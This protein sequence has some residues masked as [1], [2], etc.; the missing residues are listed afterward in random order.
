MSKSFQDEM[1]EAMHRRIQKLTQENEHLRKSRALAHPSQPS[2][3]SQPDPVYS[4]PVRPNPVSPVSPVSPDDHPDIDDEIKKMQENIM[5]LQLCEKLQIYADHSRQAERDQ[6]IEKYKKLQMEAAR[7]AQREAEMERAAQK[8]QIIREAEEERE[9]VRA[10]FLQERKEQERKEQER[11]RSSA[12]NPQEY[13]VTIGKSDNAQDASPVPVIMQRARSWIEMQTQEESDSDSEPEHE[14]QVVRRVIPPEPLPSVP[15]TF[16]LELDE[17][18]RN[19][20]PGKGMLD[21]YYSLES[22]QKG[23]AEDE[24]PFGVLQQPRRSHMHNTP[25]AQWIRDAQQA[26]AKQMREARANYDAKTSL[27]SAP[28][29]RS[30]EEKH[31]IMIVETLDGK[32][33]LEIDGVLVSYNDA[34][35]AIASFAGDD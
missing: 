29:Q 25:D 17:I 28:N 9:R 20:K 11:M 10:Q 14:S 23:Y 27:D 33:Y 31:Q 32:K 3:P 15:T 2:Q 22:V 16:E 26:R 7:Q 24:I 34:A 30:G 6:S 5:M 18:V 8:K 4:G 35:T 21:V 13:T 1:Y 19:E 12:V